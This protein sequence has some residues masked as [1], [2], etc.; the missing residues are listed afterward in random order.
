M[1]IF[2]IVIGL[3]LIVI[4]FIIGLAVFLLFFGIIENPNLLISTYRFLFGDEGSVTMPLFYGLM[5]LSGVILIKDV[6]QK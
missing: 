1:R 5:L 6:S 4:P 2:K 3:L